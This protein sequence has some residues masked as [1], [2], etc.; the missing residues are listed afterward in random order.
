MTCQSCL[1][2]ISKPNPALARYSLAACALGPVW[3]SLPAQHTCPKHKLAQPDVLKKRE[4]WLNPPPG[5]A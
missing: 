5:P 2:W 4:A 1:H 3:T